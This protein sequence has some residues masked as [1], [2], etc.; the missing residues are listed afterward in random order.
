MDPILSEPSE[1][2][3][4]WAHQHVLVR[5]IQTQKMY[6]MWARVYLGWWCKCSKDDIED[7]LDNFEAGRVCIYTATCSSWHFW[8]QIG[9]WSVL[10]ELGEEQ[11]EEEAQKKTLRD[12]CDATLALKSWVR[13][14]WSIESTWILLVAWAVPLPFLQ[15]VP[16]DAETL[17]EDTLI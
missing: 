17:E 5:Y 2:E 3:R 11:L 13:H 14:N 6:V 16:T 9:F 4:R 7:K 1:P 15:E 10:A 12:E 8:R